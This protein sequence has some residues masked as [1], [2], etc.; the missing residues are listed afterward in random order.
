MAAAAAVAE[1]VAPTA[2]GPPG[3]SVAIVGSGMSGLCMAVK[4]KQAGIAFTIFERNNALGGARA[5]RP[6]SSPSLPP[7][8]C[9]PALTAQR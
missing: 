7:S 8:G 5:R 6:L 3:F 2:F 9:R 1:A 4:L